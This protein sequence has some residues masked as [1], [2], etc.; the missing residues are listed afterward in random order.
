MS[1]H[2]DR[3]AEET[4]ARFES[5]GRQLL[6]LVRRRIGRALD[7][8]DEGRFMQALNSLREAQSAL[9]PVAQAESQM[10]FVANAEMISADQLE[11]DMELLGFGVVASVEH[12]EPCNESCDGHVLVGIRGEADQLLVSA[13]QE[14][15]VRRSNGE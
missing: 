15:Y 1:E 13:K 6:M 12:Q 11:V 10:A 5:G 9:G 4:L 3:G 2:F 7:E 8:M 14:I